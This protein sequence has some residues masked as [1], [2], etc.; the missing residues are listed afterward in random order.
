[1]MQLL[2]RV[3]CCAAGSVSEHRIAVVIVAH[4]FCD[5][6][7]HRGGDGV[8]ILRGRQQRAAEPGEQGLHLQRIQHGRLDQQ[9]RGPRWGQRRIFF[10]Q[11]LDRLPRELVAI[12]WI[13][14]DLAA[15]DRTGSDD[16]RCC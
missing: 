8:S 6:R 16:C 11:S 3:A 2:Q 15:V 14:G 4:Q 7:I 1:M 9:R 10:D 13:A 5:G 12:I